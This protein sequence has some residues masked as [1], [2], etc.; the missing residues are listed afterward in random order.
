MLWAETTIDQSE[1]AEENYSFPSSFGYSTLEKYEWDYSQTSAV[2][3]I[4]VNNIDLDATPIFL[5]ES[6]ADIGTTVTINCP[7]DITLTVPFGTNG[8]DVFWDEPTTSTN[9]SNPNITITQTSGASNGGFF[10]L[11]FT[12]IGYQANNDCGQT[13]FCN[14]SINIQQED[15]PTDDYCLQEGSTPWAEWIAGVQIA[16]INNESGKCDTEC[17]YGDFTDLVVN[18]NVGTTYDITLIPGKSWDGYLSDIYWSVW[19]D[20]NQDGD[21]TDAGETTLEEY[22]GN[23]P[24]DASISVSANVTQGTTRMRIAAQRGSFLDPCTSFERGEIEDYT[25]NIT[26]GIVDICDLS[27]QD[28]NDEDECTTNDVY[29]DDFNCVGVFTDSDN[30]GVCNALDVCPNNDDNLDFNNNGVPDGCENFI[31]PGGYCLAEAAAPWQ[32][33]IRIIRIND[34]SNESGKCAA[35]CGYGDFTSL[36]TTVE[37][38]ASYTFELT[39]KYSWQA[40]DEYW[41]VWID[42]N[43][44]EHFSGSEIV[45][46]KFTPALPDGIGTHTVSGTLNIPLNASTGEARIR[47]ALSG[48]EGYPDACGLFNQGEV[49]DY[50]INIVEPGQSLN[51]GAEP[52]NPN[53]ANE[54]YQNNLSTANTDDLISLYPNPSSGILFV[55]VAQYRNE[56]GTIRNYDNL[57]QVIEERNLE[58][59]ATDV[60][61]FDLREMRAGMYFTAIRPKNKKPKVQRS[62]L[63]RL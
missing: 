30:D 50:T 18:L 37:K 35:T 36:S 55:D 60:I 58:E 43:N 59:I 47:I 10:P 51:I 24:L 32:Q 54:I 38:G 53:A 39:A 6:G 28:C 2:S 56:I 8:I 20:W 4:S 3:E 16:N 7:A 63:I 61:E 22:G 48:A 26:D 17:G 1:F 23:Q 19:I 42:W 15:E 46:S 40:G 62:S 13:A 12:Q 5:V 34:L 52:G 14:F 45:Y 57:G 41:R 44:N 33:Y 25:L 29:D 31:D 27:G 21:F 9:C 11:G 49:E